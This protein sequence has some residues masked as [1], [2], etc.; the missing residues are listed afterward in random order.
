MAC[1]QLRALDGKIEVAGRV[2]TPPSWD[3]TE[4]RGGLKPAL[5]AKETA[6]WGFAEAPGLRGTS[7]VLR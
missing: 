7:L 3:K 4:E 5:R 1:N 2:L 6:P